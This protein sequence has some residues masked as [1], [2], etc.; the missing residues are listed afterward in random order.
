MIHPETTPAPTT[1]IPG[2]DLFMTVIRV[3]D[4]QASLRWYA[5]VLGLLPIRTDPTRGFALLAAG[6][7]R[8]A[9][10]SR[11]AGE[12]NARACDLPRLVFLVP[13]ADAEYRRLAARGVSVTPPAENTRESYLEI[14]LHDPD[15][16]PL[17]LFSWTSPDAD[18][19]AR[20]GD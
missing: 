6:T 4:W 9:L 14:R 16:I 17:S 18:P 7:G 11:R 10:Q 19:T 5:D 15:G 13:D 12:P 20:P 8:L 1:D 2:P 3:A